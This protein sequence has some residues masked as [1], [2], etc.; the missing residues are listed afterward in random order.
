[1]DKTTKFVFTATQINEAVERAY[2]KNA[3][4][5]KVQGFRDGK[6]PRK[7]I[8]QNYGEVF[9][10][11]ALNEL[12]NEAYN[13]YLGDNADIR[14]VDDPE[15]EINPTKD[16][17]LEASVTIPVQEPVKLGK[18][19]GL[20]YAKQTAKITD[21]EVEI[22]LERVANERA[23][24]VAAEKG[25]KIQ[26]GNVAVIDFVGSI[27]GVEFE[28][29]KGSNHELEIGSHSF[30]DGFE[31][32]L[33]GHVVGDKVDVK[34]TFP[35]E[36]HAKELASKPALFKVEVKNVLTK[37][38]P[39]IDDNLAKESSEFDNLV[40]FKKDIRARLEK[41]SAE[42]CERANDDEL[43]RIVCQNSNV[44]VHP[45]IVARQY[46]AVIGDLENRLAQTGISL[47]MYAMYNGMTLDQ[48]KEKQMENARLG[49]KTGIILD[50]IMQ[51][52][53]LKSFDDAIKFL[54]EENK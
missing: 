37:Q 20:T 3:G 27:N 30:I 25:H 11:P 29:G 4:K 19:K 44:T 32:Q 6:A 53:G 45:K 18:Y 13:K 42:E 34:V 40:D 48:F 22:F 1:M 17:N 7:V 15:I 12:F 49:S 28:G 47:D 8:E 51:K 5:Y 21:K 9:F 33:V 14:P 10:E 46:E 52:E 50:A 35:K 24:T 26:K 54:K 23:R 39:A 43:L 31:E 36:Y 16:G 41:H 2:K 38:I